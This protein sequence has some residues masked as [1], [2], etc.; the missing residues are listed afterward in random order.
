MALIC[1]TRHTRKG[2]SVSPF[3][4]WEDGS[5]RYVSPEE[6][7][8][9]ARALGFEVS[10]TVLK[11]RLY[12]GLYPKAAVALEAPKSKNRK[13]KK[14]VMKECAMPGC[15]NLTTRT[16]CCLSCSS[17]HTHDKRRAK[18]E[19]AKAAG[20]V[21]EK[22]E[23]DP[24]DM[25]VPI[26]RCGIDRSVK[27]FRTDNMGYRVRCKHFVNWGDFDKQCYCDCSTGYEPETP[28][29]KF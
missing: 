8:R 27:C 5:D 19:A 23:K 1:G 10:R 18:R 22:K 11:Q 6:M 16:Y 14:V 9:E 13:K 26:K 3:Y 21:V 17:Q 4:Q 7:A 28:L 15:T 12:T 20:E 25:P 29:V 24:T 2:N